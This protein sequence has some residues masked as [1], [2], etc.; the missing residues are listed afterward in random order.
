MKKVGE[1]KK[2]IYLC[3]SHERHLIN[4]LEALNVRKKVNLITKKQYKKQLTTLLRGRSV[5]DW[6]NYYNDYK[7]TCY[8][9]IGEH[10]TDRSIRTVFFVL[11][12]LVLLA[13]FGLQYTGYS[14]SDQKMVYVD[15]IVSSNA[16]LL[17]DGV[18]QSIPFDPEFYNGQY[19]YKINY[20][21]IPN[22]AK[23]IEIMDNN[24]IIFVKEI[25]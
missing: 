11:F 15:K 2:H 19:V 25:K 22:S 7:S 5:D 6:L 3:D 16:Y 14:V 13:P 17:I 20:L 9:M 10:N 23:K 21:Q 4:E 18:A 8:K 1:L 24:Q 12:L